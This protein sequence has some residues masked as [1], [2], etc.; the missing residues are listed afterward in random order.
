MQNEE[1]RRIQLELEASQ[2]RYFDL[3]EL[4]PVGYCILSDKGLIL[5]AN[6]TVA[7]LLN[8]TRNKLIKTPISCFI[9]KADQD[10]YYRYHKQ[11]VESGEPQA[12]EL[13]MVKNDGT[14]FWAH[15]TATTTLDVDGKPVQRL[16]LND[17]TAHKQA[18]EALRESEDHLNKT[19][20][21]GHVGSWVWYPDTREVFWSDETYRLLGYAPKEVVPSYELFLERVHPDDRFRVSN[22]FNKVVYEN[23]PYSFDF[24]IITPGGLE[25]IVYSQGHAVFDESGKP[26]H[27]L[28]MILDISERKHIRGAT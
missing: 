12:C 24:R 23:L 26:R 6:L 25:R 9:L 14:Q 16:T 1:L 20:A 2:A 15:L 22:T 19:Q 28:G 21:I 13:R 18:E 17:I 27:L 4:A 5:Q 7:N 3:Y 8:V 11:L 10:V